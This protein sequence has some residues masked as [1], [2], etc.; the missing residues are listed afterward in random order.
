MKG[1]GFC[2][3]MMRPQW[4][5]SN[6]PQEAMAYCQQMTSG[7]LPLLCP[8]FDSGSCAPSEPMLGREVSGEHDIKYIGQNRQSTWQHLAT[9]V[10]LILIEK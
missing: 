5:K 3:W 1:G 7:D 4:G 9:T 6:K 8:G 10:S 2:T